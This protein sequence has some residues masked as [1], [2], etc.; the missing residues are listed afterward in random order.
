MDD[1]SYCRV[2]LIICISC[3]TEITKRVDGQYEA[4]HDPHNNGTYVITSGMNELN[5]E[6]RT[7]DG[8]YTDKI[9]FS[10]TDVANDCKVEACS[11]SQVFS[12]IDYSTNYCNIHSLY[13]ADEGCRPFTELSYSETVGTCSASDDVCLTM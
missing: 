13:C 7:G 6:R 4:W 9:L 11:E 2:F 12:S 5:L 3:R 8:K 10:F 1:I